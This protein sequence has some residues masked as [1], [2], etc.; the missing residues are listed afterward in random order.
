[1]SALSILMIPATLVLNTVK[2]RLYTIVVI[3]I[4]MTDAYVVEFGKQM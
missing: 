2:Y 3:A 1:M 4:A